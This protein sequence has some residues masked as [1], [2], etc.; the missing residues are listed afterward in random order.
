[1]QN[2]PAARCD[3]VEE[4]VV[5]M[6]NLSAENGKVLG[7]PVK[8]RYGM[9]WTSGHRTRPLNDLHRGNGL[10]MT[11][12]LLLNVVRSVLRAAIV[13]ETYILSEV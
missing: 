2:H 6:F 12:K 13:T 3:V 7:R 9:G 4:N 10:G 11:T 8:R 5:K 1:M